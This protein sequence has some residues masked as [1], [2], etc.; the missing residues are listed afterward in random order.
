[1]MDI[2]PKSLFPYTG[3]RGEVRPDRTVKTGSAMPTD[4]NRP[5]EPSITLSDGGHE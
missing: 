4:N 5:S 1:M 3:K 2:T